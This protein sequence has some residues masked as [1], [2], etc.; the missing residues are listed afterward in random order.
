M[1]CYYTSW[2]TIVDM[3]GKYGFDTIK[4][5]FFDHMRRACTCFLSR[6]KKESHCSLELILT[7]TE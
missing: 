2:Y 3:H 1:S 5:T 7:L 4:N 6:L